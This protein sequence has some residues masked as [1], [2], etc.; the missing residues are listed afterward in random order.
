MIFEKILIKKI[1]LYYCLCFII[2]FILIKTF[3]KTNVL[4]LIL[5]LFKKRIGIGTGIDKQN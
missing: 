1:N 2:K 3:I 5:K 4:Y